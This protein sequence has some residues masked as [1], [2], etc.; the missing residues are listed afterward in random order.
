MTGPDRTLRRYRVTDCHGD[1]IGEGSFS[2][3]GQA[4]EWA[5][6]LEIDGGCILHHRTS[7]G[8]SVLRRYPGTSSVDARQSSRRS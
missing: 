3:F 6:E 1:V 5:A 7:T 4:K 2:T 8:W